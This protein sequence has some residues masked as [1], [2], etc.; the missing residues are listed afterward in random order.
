[1]GLEL[2]SM[3]NNMLA[4]IRVNAETM[5][6]TN[7]RLLVGLGVMFVYLFVGAIVFCRI[8]SPMERIEME[9]YLDYRAQ[10]TER[11]IDLGIEESEVDH[12]FRNIREASL[13]GIW[14]EKNVT[15]DPNWSLGSAFFFA[16]TLIT[17]VGYGRVSPR[18]AHG[19]LF[20]IIYCVVGIPL[21]LALLSALVTR[22]KQPSV[23]L[24][25]KL[26][27]KLG[28]LFGESQLQ[29]FHLGAIMSLLLFFAFIIPSWIFSNIENDWSFL[30]AFYYCFVSLTTIGLGDYQPGDGPDVE[31]RGFYKFL[32]TVYLLFGL[33]CMMLF[34]S[35][36]YDLPQFNISKFFLVKDGA[37][38][39]EDRGLA[40]DLDSTRYTKF[41]PE[42]P[43]A[44]QNGFYQSENP[45][46][47]Q[48]N[49]ESIFA[50]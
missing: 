42:T 6:E 16:G 3:Q 46:I 5:R 44:I 19:K 33:C 30:D 36:L 12:L 29:L 9:L 24:R 32:A 25:S 28:H 1:M 47:H 21:A 48:K 22:M 49:T 7:K 4:Q 43:T 23:W 10:W 26:N 2:F 37:Y 39:D 18:T 17:T 38:F 14:M 31:F 20:T 50:R 40:A 27:A 45:Q 35:S 13:N 11:L 34:L 15:N 41:A 8:E